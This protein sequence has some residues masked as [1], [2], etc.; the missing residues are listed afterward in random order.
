[1]PQRALDVGRLL[2]SA[3][4]GD[5]RLD[6]ALHPEADPVD[7]TANQCR[8]HVLRKRSGR[9]FDGDLNIRSQFEILPNVDKNA[10]QLCYIQESRRA[11][12]EVN[13]INC[14]LEASA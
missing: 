2:R 12:T 11:A 6:E 8:D 13:G 9:A 5:F 4:G 10:F 3:G 1:M 14:A 7:S